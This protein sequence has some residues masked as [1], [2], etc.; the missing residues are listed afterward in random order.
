MRQSDFGKLAKDYNNRT[1]LSNRVLNQLA[2]YAGADKFEQILKDME[3]E[4]KEISNVVVP[5]KTSAW[6]AEAKV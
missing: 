1:D 3:Y 6:T 4:I 5:C 2:S